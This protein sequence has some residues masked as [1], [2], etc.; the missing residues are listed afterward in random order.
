MAATHI[1]VRL[2]R[3]AEP[4]ELIGPAH[5]W[6]GSP[7]ATLVAPDPR[8]IG[9]SP[10]APRGLTW[11]TCAL[12]ADE[13]AARATFETSQTAPTWAA[14]AVESWTGLMQPFYHKG[15]TTWLD[16]RVAGPMFVPGEAPGPDAPCAVITSAGWKL[17][18]GFDK[19]RMV[20]FGVKSTAVRASMTN[21]P[22]LH[23]M[24]AFCEAPISSGRD[25]IT[26]TFW[27]DPSWMQKFAYR[28]GLHRTIMDEDQKNPS[29]LYDRSS[30]TR[31]RAL[32]TRGSWHG[33]DPLNL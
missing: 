32:A 21:T 11:L 18:P 22:G 19:Q 2:I 9:L 10:G 4:V 14:N 1:T 8:E 5:G 24:H 7:L 30:F 12:F 17:G 13:A 23:S 31:L 27:R 25:L 6:T 15:T 3:F 16:P 20:D 26:L 33:S 28:Q 29:P